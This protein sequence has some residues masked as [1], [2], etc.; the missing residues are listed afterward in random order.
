MTE[1]SFD[2]VL[3]REFPEG[4]AISEELA[5]IEGSYKELMPFDLEGLDDL[6]KKMRRF[7][8]LQ[9]DEEHDYGV[10]P[11]T[12]AKTLYKPGAEKLQTLFGF[13]TETVL[14]DRV[15]QWD[16]PVSARSF[17]VFHY[18]YTTRVY[19]RDGRMI[20]SCDGETNSY[21]V[22]YRW[23][24]VPQHEVPSYL[25]EEDLEK[26]ERKEVEFAFAIDKAETTGQYGKPQAYW[27]SWKQDIEAG[28]V[29]R[30]K[31]QTKK[32][33]ELDAYERGGT[34]YRIPNED[35]YSQI[36]TLI[37]MAIK[38]SYVGAIM[39][40][41]NASAFF[42]QDMEDSYESMTQT[43]TIK[44]MVPDPQKAKMALMKYV[45]SKGISDSGA[46]IRDIL[47]EH[48]VAF[49]LDN[50]DTIVEMI[51]DKLAEELEVEL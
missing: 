46:F 38:R 19:N 35:I 37:K 34:Q 27:D 22:K 8:S 26:R 13:S 51:D 14:T 21:E 49:S 7:V 42:T 30:I 25:Y 17:P 15:E 10:I 39:V 44:S 45:V 4:E 24:W 32:G 23:R 50:W 18:I 9:M 43:P 48:E 1:E 33:N 6:Y 28:I 41:C 2:Q 36:N 16:V 40:A 3:A 12:A 5:I 11:G 47:T 29:T 20:A 31:K